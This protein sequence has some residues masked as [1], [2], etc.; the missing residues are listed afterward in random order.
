MVT[1]AVL[2]HKWMMKAL[3]SLFILSI[4]TLV[5]C[6]KSK[7]KNQGCL[8]PATQ[9]EF[10]GGYLFAPNI[11]TPNGDGYT[12]LFYPQ[13]QNLSSSNLTIST[14]GGKQVFQTSNFS[15]YW[16]GECNGK[17]K[18]GIYKYEISGT[19]GNGENINAIG[20]VCVIQGNEI[21]C[22]KNHESCAYMATWTDSTGFIIDN[23]H[24]SDL[25]CD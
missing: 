15:E 7:T 18:S 20:E 9:I 2:E 8:S 1:S 23:S 24:A 11:I 25:S 10:N 5:S 14:T 6:R 3:L 12:D 13:H 22:I 16:N 17:V 4:L 19:T 21:N